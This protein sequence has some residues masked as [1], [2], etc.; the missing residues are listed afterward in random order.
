MTTYV[1]QKHKSVQQIIVIK[2]CIER[3]KL[4]LRVR[5]SILQK[6]AKKKVSSAA[7]CNS[8]LLKANVLNKHHHNRGPLSLS[9]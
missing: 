4:Y 5:L 6:D 2:Y 8:V 9:V 7:M 3:K 1:S